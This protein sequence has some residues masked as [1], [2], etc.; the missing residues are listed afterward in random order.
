V[1]APARLLAILIMV[2]LAV[3]ITATAAPA[4]HRPGPCAIEREEGQGVRSW[5][6]RVIRCAERRWPV[7]GG[8]RRAI[9]IARHESDLDPKARSPGGAYLGLFQ[10]SAEAWPHRYEEWTRRAWQLDPR[11]KNGRTNAIVTLR[12]VN[13]HGWGP[14]RGV[15]GC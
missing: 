11:A 6:R 4:T 3:P 2:T 13:T 12:M 8:A 10:H 1:R 5:V 9:C 7:P 15:D 14:W